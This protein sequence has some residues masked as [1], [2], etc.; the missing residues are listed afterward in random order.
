MELISMKKKYENRFKFCKIEAN[1]LA[2]SKDS[3]IVWP[4]VSISRGIEEEIKFDQ[5]IGFGVFNLV[6]TFL[7][8]LQIIINL[9]TSILKYVYL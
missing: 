5:C 8:Q 2:L 1:K 7:F 4:F 9:L 3:V 6:R